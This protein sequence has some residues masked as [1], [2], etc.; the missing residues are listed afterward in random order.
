MLR[1]WQGCCECGIVGRVR[2]ATSHV[3]VHPTHNVG[4]GIDA[5]E[6]EGSTRL[7]LHTITR[8]STFTYYTHPVRLLVRLVRRIEPVSYRATSTRYDG[9]RRGRGPPAAA[10]VWGLGKSPRFGFRLCA[11]G[12]PWL[13]AR[14]LGFGHWGPA[15]PL[16]YLLW[17]RRLPSPQGPPAAASDALACPSSPRSPVRARAASE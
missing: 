14:A 13:C 3:A 5:T 17:A 16:C 4:R 15:V 1:A 7:N 9:P 6:A 12:F 2:N 8:C 11:V 10:T